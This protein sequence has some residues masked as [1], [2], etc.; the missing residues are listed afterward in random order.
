MRITFLGLATFEVITEDGTRILI[1]PFLDDNPYS[2]VKVRDVNSLDLILVSHGAYDHLGDAVEIARRTG[3][4]IVCGLEVQRV[5]VEQGI[6]ASAI[7]TLSWGLST[8]H[9][10]IR[11]RAVESRHSSFV[12]DAG[13]NL[14]CGFPLGFI[15]DDGR[16]RLYNASDTALFS[17]MKLI[18]QLMKPQVGLINVSVPRVYSKGNSPLAPFTTGEMTGEE[19]SLAAEWLGL[20]Y[21]IAC[22]YEDP[23]ASDV[24]EFMRLLTERRRE[25][26]SGPEPL[27]LK[28]G[29]TVVI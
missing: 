6:S 10:G 13:G 27:L 14:L 12:S 3:A 24:S 11:I 19:A 15:V 17:D 22:H 28:P 5:M 1:D 25:R 4:K 7:T 8:E 16:T 21:A 9:N 18:G 29:E 26:D 2:P 20:R 23:S